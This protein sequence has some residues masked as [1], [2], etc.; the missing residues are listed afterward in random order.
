MDNT[1]FTWGAPIQ[2]PV[3]ISYDPPKDDFYKA[4]ISALEDREK[5]ELV[6]HGQGRIRRKASGTGRRESETR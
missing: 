2:E 3:K 5:G 4:R 6:R 1:N